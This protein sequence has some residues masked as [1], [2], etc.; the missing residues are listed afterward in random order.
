[1]QQ[2]SRSTDLNFPDLDILASVRRLWKVKVY[3]VQN[4]AIE[5]LPVECISSCQWRW[6]HP[7]S[8]LCSLV[9]PVPTNQDDLSVVMTEMARSLELLP[10]SSLIKQSHK[11]Q[12]HQ[13]LYS[14]GSI[15]LLTWIAAC[16]PPILIP[17]PPTKLWEY[18]RTV[19]VTFLQT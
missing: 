19:Q 7:C 3:F 1:M 9:L 18:L 16:L 8:H 4:F 17:V 5:T 2:L 13:C 14:F 6:L 12:Q 11:T 10:A 15:S